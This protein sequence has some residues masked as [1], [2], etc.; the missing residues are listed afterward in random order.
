[1]THPTIITLSGSCQCVILDGELL[2][3][4]TKVFCQDL[5][6]LQYMFQGLNLQILTLIDSHC[7]SLTVV[8][9]QHNKV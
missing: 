7:I 4:C 9:L 6:Y 5:F 2:F 1:M 8:C 3:Y